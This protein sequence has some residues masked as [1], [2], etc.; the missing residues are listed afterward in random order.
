M[1]W[2]SV[3]KRY[4][5]PSPPQNMPSRMWGSGS[6]WKAENS[7]PRCRFGEGKRAAIWNIWG[8]GKG[9]DRLG[10][11]IENW[12]RGS[13]GLGGLE[14]GRARSFLGS[15]EDS[16]VCAAEPRRPFPLRSWEVA[17][18]AAGLQAPVLLS[19][20]WESGEPTSWTTWASQRERLS[21]G[22]LSFLGLA[23][24]G[25]G[26]RRGGEVVLN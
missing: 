6:I 10:P 11:N 16:V 7:P 2:K 20:E 19:R 23:G 5:P 25:L 21:Q 17:A 14:E 13:A 24:R 8:E 22:V 9:G 12:T 1:V 26:L 4:A 3:Q 15:P 18:A